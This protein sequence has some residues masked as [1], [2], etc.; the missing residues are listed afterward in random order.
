MHAANGSCKQ[1]N[2]GQPAFGRHA[3]AGV[4]G[5]QSA[6]KGT[7]ASMG[8][9]IAL[10]LTSACARRRPS[11]RWAQP[12]VS[13]SRKMTKQASSPRHHAAKN[14]KMPNCAAGAH[15]TSMGFMVARAGTN[16]P[17]RMLLRLECETPCASEKGTHVKRKGA[18]LEGAQHGKERLP[19]QECEEEVHC[20]CQSLSRTARLQRL[21]LAGQQPSLH[22]HAA[23]KS[24]VSRTTSPLQPFT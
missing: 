5:Q 2:T 15:F 12:L 16:L 10:L 21:D 1:A 3:R 11:P 9:A 4:K 20:D 17:G 19:D 8:E 13:G 6:I 23:L 18:H 24:H 22:M 14:R 7:G